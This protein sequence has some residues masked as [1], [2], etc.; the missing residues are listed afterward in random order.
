MSADKIAD[1]LIDL[2][3]QLFRFGQ[4]TKR[5]AFAV[6][7]KGPNVALCI[8]GQ[9]E[10]RFRA[11]LAK[12]FR[13]A[14]KKTPSKSQLGDAT[15][16]LLGDCFD[17]PP[18]P[19]FR[20]VAPCQDCG[21]AVD[22]GRP[23]GKTVLIYP[24]GP[25]RWKVSDRSPVLFERSDLTGEMPLPIEGGSLLEIQET[26][27]L[28]DPHWALFLGWILGAFDPQIHHPILAIFGPAGAG[29]SVLARLAV[30]LCDP[31][32][33][34]LRSLPHSEE[35]WH[36]SASSSWLYAMD[37]VSEIKPWLADALCKAAT[38]DARAV[39][40]LY[41]SKSLSVTSLD[42]PVILTA[43]EVGALRADFGNRLVMLELP[44]RD[45]REMA[46]ERD[47]NTT[48]MERL[49]SWFGAICDA[50]SRVLE[51]KP[52]QRLPLGSPRMADYAHLLLCADKAG[53]TVDAYPEYERN[54]RDAFQEVAD[55]DVLVEAITSFLEGYPGG[56]WQGSATKLLS[57]LN[58]LRR[59]ERAP[60]WPKSANALSMRLK[61]LEPVMKNCGVD[62][63]ARRE[64]TTRLKV[65]SLSLSSS[66]KKEK[67]SSGSFGSSGDPQF[68]A[69][70]SQNLTDDNERS[71]DDP[72]KLPSDRPDDLRT[73]SGRWPSSSKPD[74]PA[75]HPGPSGQPTSVAE[76]I[77]CRR[78]H[79]EN[80]VNVPI[81]GG[82]SA[83]RDCGDCG[84]FIDFPSWHGSTSSNTLRNAN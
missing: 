47:L 67:R 45:R 59:H 75:K 55:G 30:Q 69:E 54:N 17:A 34:P 37:N 27:R 28:S 63:D 64:N 25:V 23:D 40:R 21:I 62:Y 11:T 82:K 3:H 84:A 22:L 72:T 74:A 4:N 15:Q 83:R 20:R 19:T 41:S 10:S 53:V 81:H 29:K 73:I 65:I 78:C 68:A 35:D 39:R 66:S 18:E 43:I 14:H 5:E 2:A 12:E 61:R 51:Q 56:R 50:V 26:I 31:S 24:N 58:A 36:I 33:C 6:A 71:P 16:V 46:L 60:D 49:P 38:G 32:P 52:F 7:K 42:L 57:H 79:S 48:V 77:A 80:V 9:E 8:A 70:K 76:L 44:R 1:Q 13:M